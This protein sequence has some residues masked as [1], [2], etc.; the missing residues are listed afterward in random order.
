MMLTGYAMLSEPVM[1][2]D[3]KYRPGSVRRRRICNTF[4]IHET[5]KDLQ[6]LPDP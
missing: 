5:A 4:Q 1:L 2:P 6:C 3:L